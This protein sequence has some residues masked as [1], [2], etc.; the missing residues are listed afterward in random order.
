VRLRLLP[1][2][3][4]VR[5][6]ADVDATDAVSFADFDDGIVVGLVVGV[7]VA[8]LLPFVLVLLVFSLELALVLLLLPLVMAGQLV[9]LLPWVLV[10]RYDDG[11]RYHEVRG[12][13]AMLAAR[14]HLRSR[15]GTSAVL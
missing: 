4:K 12:T 8:L 15:V 7:V 3:P 11:K 6:W 14:R 10:L 1:W 9:G 13:R 5:E 2:R